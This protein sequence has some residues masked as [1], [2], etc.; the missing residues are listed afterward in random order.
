MFDCIRYSEEPE[1]LYELVLNDPAYREMN[2]DTYDLIAQYIKTNELMRVK[3]Y[4]KKEGKVDMCRA[5][6]E[7]IERGRKE[8]IQQGLRDGARAF[9]EASISRGAAADYILEMVQQCF[10]FS[11]ENADELY[12]ECM[13]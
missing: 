1:K 12:R 4:K 8:G 9:V 6:A 2:R 3:R 10:G 13:L 11:R 7:L 5:I